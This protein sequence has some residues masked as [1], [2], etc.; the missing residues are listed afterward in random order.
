L[1]AAKD[2]KKSANGLTANE[3]ND[4]SDSNDNNPAAIMAAGFLATVDPLADLTQAA[5]PVLTATAP[6]IDYSYKASLLAM[7]P[8]SILSTL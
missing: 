8:P 2:K 7:N 4:R 6:L 3:S 1:K 5:V